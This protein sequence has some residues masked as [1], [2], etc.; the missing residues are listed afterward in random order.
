M[1]TKERVAREQ[2]DKQPS[3][4][5]KRPKGKPLTHKAGIFKIVGIGDSKIPGG[6][7]W[8][9]HDLGL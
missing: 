7:S 9:K 5:V 6:F 4:V 1:A 2:P 8:R 3:E